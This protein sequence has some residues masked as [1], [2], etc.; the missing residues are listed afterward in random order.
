MIKI[1]S[2]L[3]RTVCGVVFTLNV[4]ACGSSASISP[5]S[6]GR[7]SSG[8]TLYVSALADPGG[9]GSRAAPFSSLQALEQASQAGDDL[10]VL[11]VSL[12]VPALD[13]GI[14]LKP[15]QRLLG[16]GPDV[17]Q[18]R[19]NA[20]VAG[21]AVLN[22]LPR[23]RNTNLLR[24]EGD[25][26]R[27]AELSEV[28]NLVI[29]ESARGGIYGLNVPGASV[30]GNDLSG[31]NTT[32]TVGFTVEPFVLPTNVPLVGV[33]IALPAGWA[34]ILIDADRGTGVVKIT[35][36]HVHNSACGNGIDLRI[37]GSADYVAT[38]SGNLVTQLERGPL[39]QAG[40]FLVHAIT[41]QITDHGRLA[42]TSINNT[43]TFIGAE[44]AD[45]EGLFMNLSD[46]AIGTWTIDRNYF[47][48]GIGGFSCNGMELVVSNGSTH[49]KMILS[50]SY[51]EDNPGDMLEQ[52]NF[53]VASTVIL[54]IENVVVKDTHER[55]GDPD[56]SGAP[57]NRGIPG[58]LGDCLVTGS[59]G[60][61]N[62]TRLK[63]SNSEF[64]GCNN[65][66]SLLSGINL[67]NNV[68][69]GVTSGSLSP[70]LIAPDGLLQAEISNSVFRDNANSNLVVTV[71]APLRELSVKVENSDFSRAGS[72]TVL[73]RKLATGSVERSQIDFGGAELGSA[74]GNCIL[75]GVPLDVRSEGF[76]AG[77]RGNWWGQAGGPSP[78]RISQSEP[79]SLDLA[80]PLDT[81]P[82]I[83]SPRRATAQVRN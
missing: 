20:A 32:C 19:D 81:A 8:R 61:G 49:A 37:N 77:M 46:S 29:T 53:G 38:V 44:G 16:G 4:V 30:H 80:A 73:L 12:D 40:E 60:S 21:A 58:N 31:Y 42:A 68:L 47:A 2:T 36:N 1:A 13:G 9:D 7:I 59:T 28:R 35:D 76:F 11:P 79:G 14:T 75:G 55:G 51:F 78:E 69:G 15:H 74:G 17:V 62:T 3:L 27:L 39:Y 64:S 23:I 56:F 5:S 52:L 26:V 57:G 25:A 70:N 18:H 50:N 67:L 54:E 22:A 66:L 10:V 43:Q 65:G 41:L 82:V 83:C 34:G 33:P 6:E 63:I 24:L 71:L 45:C 72:S 48:H